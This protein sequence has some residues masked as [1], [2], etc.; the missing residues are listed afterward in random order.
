MRSKKKS[1]FFGDSRC[2]RLL[3]FVSRW[4]FEG[5]SKGAI[6]LKGEISK[7][8]YKLVGNVQCTDG[9]SYKDSFYK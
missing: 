4:S 1:N 2:E 6:V 3:I 5:P 7:G 8:L 9:R